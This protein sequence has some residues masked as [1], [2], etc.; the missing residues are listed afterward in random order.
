MGAAAV[1]AVCVLGGVAT[2][3]VT[4]ALPLPAGGAAPAPSTSR[5]A[6]SAAVPLA[7]SAT[8]WPRDES[9]PAHPPAPSPSPS[10]VG[11]CHA[12]RA[13]DKAEPGKALESPAF[14]ALV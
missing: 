2:A 4:G 7:T 12:Y 11:L 5:P 1:G 9:G 14:T 13:G 3:A 8:T 6:P 10:L